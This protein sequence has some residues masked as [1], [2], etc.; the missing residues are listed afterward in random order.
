MKI[1]AQNIS[2]ISFAVV[3]ELPK[4]IDNEQDALEIMMNCRYSGFDRMALRKEL[5]QPDVFELSN[6]IAGGIFQ[7]FSNYDMKLAVIGDFV[8]LESKSLRDFIVE[9]NKPRQVIFI[10]DLR[11]VEDY[12][13]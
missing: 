4:P 1:E 13:K 12:W 3:S 9:S 10:P 7:K 11:S 8:Q 6:G 5:F 2:N